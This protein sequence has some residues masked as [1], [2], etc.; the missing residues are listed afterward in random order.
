MNRQVDGDVEHSRQFGQ[1]HAQ[2]KDVA[3]TA[4]AKVH[5]HGRG[6][7]KNREWIAGAA[8]QQLGAH[9]QRVVSRMSRAKHPLIATDRANTSPHL[10]GQRL[11]CQP[12]VSGSERAR[13]AIAQSL[14]RLGRE[15]DP[16]R[17]FISA[18]EQL[19]VAAERESSVVARSSFRLA[20]K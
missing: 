12:A 13:K 2:K 16:D 3:P 10:I 7:V 17:F 9:A 14:G 20:G 8:P 11:E 18:A 4:V 15:K 1:I 6:F 5:P 19:F